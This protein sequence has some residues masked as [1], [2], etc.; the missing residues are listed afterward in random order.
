MI[1]PGAGRA[2]HGA[3]GG[4]RKV[5]RASGVWAVWAGAA[6]GERAVRRWWR[7]SG[8]AV[9]AGA[10]RAGPYERGLGTHWATEKQALSSGAE[11]TECERSAMINIQQQDNSELLT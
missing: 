8:A 3:G 11:P 1:G 6:A 10:V 9:R 5:A 7:A 4:V 2:W